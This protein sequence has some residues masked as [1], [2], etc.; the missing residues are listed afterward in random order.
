[1]GTQTNPQNT[2]THTH[3]KQQIIWRMTWRITEDKCMFH[4]FSSK[5]KHFV[6]KEL[7][8]RSKNYMSRCEKIIRQ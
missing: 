6:L 1:M 5:K 2:H 7:H 3:K 8:V 4:N